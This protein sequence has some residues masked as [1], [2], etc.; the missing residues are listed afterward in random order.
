MRELPTYLTQD[1]FQR[2]FKVITSPRDR[3][4]FALIYHDGRR[5][6]EASQLTLDDIDITNHRI[7]I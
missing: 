2:F 6:D 3:A 1:E 5:V 7:R 4:L